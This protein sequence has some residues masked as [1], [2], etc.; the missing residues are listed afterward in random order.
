MRTAHR[1]KF[2]LPLGL[3]RFLKPIFLTVAAV[4]VATAGEMFALQLLQAAKVRRAG[5]GNSGDETSG[6]RFGGRYGI[7]HD[8]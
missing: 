5:M 3:T 7:I 2:R 6:Y 4:Q 1:E 8:V